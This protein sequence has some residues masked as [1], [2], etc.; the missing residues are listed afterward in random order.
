[1]VYSVNTLLNQEHTYACLYL[2]QAVI[3]PYTMSSLNVLLQCVD[4]LLYTVP[5]WSS[6]FCVVISNADKTKLHVTMH[7]QT[8][9]KNLTCIIK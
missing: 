8:T 9:Y 5:P 3:S 4:Q 6:N 1:M 2:L 7:A